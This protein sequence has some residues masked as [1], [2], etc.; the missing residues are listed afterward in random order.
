MVYH[1]HFCALLIWRINR[2][3]R[4][5][6]LVVKYNRRDIK[7]PGG[8]N[9]DRRDETVDETLH[10][11]IRKETGLVLPK[12]PGLLF[13]T[14]PVDNRPPDPPGTH[15]KYF[16]LTR[17]ED[18]AGEVVEGEFREDESGDWL[19]VM[20]VAADELLRPQSRFAI[21]QTH[22]RPLQQAL[23]VIQLPTDTSR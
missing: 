13:S 8:T 2:N 22:R 14:D 7:F 15:Q 6:F 1:T 18:C 3:G 10:R 12:T 23:H 4:P 20:W 19:E 21:Y 11:E 9:N 5:E 17:Y 16:Y